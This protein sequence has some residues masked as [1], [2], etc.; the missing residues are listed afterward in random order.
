LLRLNGTL[1]RINI[2]QPGPTKDLFDM[3]ERIMS[4]F[5]PIS[6][7]SDPYAFLVPKLDANYNVTSILTSA[8]AVRERYVEDSYGK[9]SFLDA[10]WG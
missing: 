10:T 2:E 7:A 1:I 5:D 6:G 4:H 9:P 3:V 8:G